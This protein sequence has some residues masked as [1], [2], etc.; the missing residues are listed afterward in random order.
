MIGLVKLRRS[1]GVTRSKLVEEVAFFAL[2]PRTFVIY[3]GFVAIASGL[4]AYR[5]TPNLSAVALGVLVAM[6]G[7]AAGAVV[8][9]A[10]R[11]VVP[12][13]H[14]W[15]AALLLWIA[16]PIVRHFAAVSVS[17]IEVGSQASVTGLSV[18]LSVAT[19][20]VWMFLIAGLQGLN[21]LQRSTTEGLRFGVERLRAETDRRWVELDQER[22]RLATL[23]QRT[24]TPALRELID[25]VSARDV[26]GPSSGFA[27]LASS[28]A[29]ESR[30]LVREASHEMK[31]L[32]DRSAKLGQPLIAEPESVAAI[33]RSRPVLA[34]ARARIEP[35]STLVALLALGFAAPAPVHETLVRFLMAVMIAFACLTGIAWMLPR[36]PLP[37]TW[38]PLVFVVCGNAIGVA[39]GVALSGALIPSLVEA[40][41]VTMWLIPDG[42]RWLEVLVWGIGTVVTTAVSLIVADRRVWLDSASQLA[43]TRDA[44]NSLDVDMQRQYDRMAAQTA[45]MLHGPIQ[46]RLATVGMTLRFAGDQITD[47]E[48]AG[49]DALLREC[50]KDLVRAALDPY[51]DRA[52]AWH[53]LDALRTQWSGLMGVTWVLTPEATDQINADPILVRNLET[54]VADLAN[55]ASRHGEAKKVEFV[56]SL[57]PSRLRVLARDNGNGPTFPVERGIGLGSLSGDDPTISIDPDGWCCVTATISRG[58]LG[59]TAVLGP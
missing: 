34:A 39:G 58:E 22:S 56:I 7:L 27:N 55:N 52:S 41:P 6:A 45:A 36:L 21:S 16:L 20:L 59:E 17:Q 5:W 37:K 11:A 53:V 25:V 51:R 29:E 9:G 57:T 14:M 8:A 13:V 12:R 54:L 19:S 24:I 50:E 30:S 3:G 47:E 33:R 18:L 23:V 49:L 15:S 1:L 2:S 10:L 28:I 40:S 31:N 46:G 44:L 48:L 38:P 42:S 43:T 35:A 26:I 4:R 32:A